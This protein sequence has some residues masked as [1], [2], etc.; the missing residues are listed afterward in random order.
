MGLEEMVPAGGSLLEK[1]AESVPFGNP[2]LL[3]RGK[4]TAK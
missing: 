3:G 1:L 4:V 2:L